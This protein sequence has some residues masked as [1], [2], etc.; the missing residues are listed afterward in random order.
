MS[1][2]TATTA[3]PGPATARALRP[4]RSVIDAVVF[5]LTTWISTSGLRGPLW[6]A[7]SRAAPGAGRAWGGRG[8][9][10]AAGAVGHAGLGRVQLRHHRTHPLQQREDREAQGAADEPAVVAYPG[11]Q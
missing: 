1:G 3:V 9:A 11:E 5:G 8:P 7:L 4:M 10:S 6:P 2:C